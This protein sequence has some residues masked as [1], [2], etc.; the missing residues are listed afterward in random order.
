MNRGSICLVLHAH[1]PF[2]HHPEHRDSLEERWFHEAMLETY[3]P[4]LEVFG[5]LRAERVPFRITMS[6]TPTLLSMFEDGLLR[7]R[8]SARL[9]L[10]L[11]L[12]ELEVARTRAAAPA[13]AESAAMYLDRF[14][15]ARALYDAL[16]RDLVRGF[17]SLQDSGQLE[18]ITCG[19]TH[20]YLPLMETTPKAV[21]A[22][23]AVA[24]N[25]HE[26]LLGRRPEGIWLP[27][28]AFNPGDD[29]VLAR[30]GLR[31][32]FVDTHGILFGT[33]RP[34]YGVFAPVFCP[35]GVAA[36]GRDPES[37]KQVWSTLEGYPGDPEYR[38]FYR[39][40]GFDLPEDY[41]KPYI[42]ESGLRVATGLKYFRITGHSDHKEP[43]RPGPA[44]EKA[45]E[46]AGNFMFNREQQAEHLFGAL[47]RAPVIVAPY[48]AELFGHWWFE[49]PLWLDFLI[50]KTAFD[51]HTVDLV[52]PADYLS[53]Q[54]LNQ[55]SMPSLSSWG[56]LGYNE[57]WLEGSND[58]IYR[59]LHMAGIRM[60][61]L[62]GRHRGAG[63]L[64]AEALNQAARELLLA[65]A[66]D[67]A[68]IMKT[69]TMV[70]YAVQRTVT[71]LGRFTRLYDDIE[72][73]RVDSGWLADVRA[74][75]NLFPDLDFRV[76]A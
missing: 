29:E 7:D 10:L 4:L 50:R 58:W 30:H 41:I 39:D 16:D 63:G 35:S 6:L 25:T 46:H 19:A 15:R 23:I 66:S 2:V 60:T 3:L 20:G 14:R 54:P 56:H 34:K 75:D 17:R 74:K 24:V 1:L 38:E 33:P 27:E 44:R 73:G 51:Q 53:R 70:P 13:F 42:H 48:D 12:A 62:A 22:Q 72:H 71:H 8:F 64:T 47:G 76:Y 57:V 43:Y 40:I 21:E 5:T 55:V 18:L 67:W 37:S 36:F 61:E 26:R 28:C 59:H 9:D 52:T 45:A 32:F 65:Q 49:G 31:Y 68:F 11:E 69:R